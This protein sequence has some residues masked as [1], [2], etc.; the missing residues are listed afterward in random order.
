MFYCDLKSKRNLVVLLV[1]S[2][3]V[4]IIVNVAIKSNIQYTKRKATTRGLSR[5]IG[6]LEESSGYVLVKDYPN[7]V[8]SA[9][10]GLL[11]LQCW[12]GAVSKNVRIVEPF[13]VEESRLGFSLEWDDSVLLKTEVVTLS[14]FFDLDKWQRQLHSMGQKYTHAVMEDWRKFLKSAP[15][16]LIV[17]ARESNKARRNSSSQ[18]FYKAV[19]SW[20]SKHDFKIV[21]EVL[22]KEKKY[23]F[24]K[25][26]KLIYGR[27]PPNKVV[28][29]FEQWG[30]IAGKIYP[31]SYTITGINQCLK[32]KYTKF[33]FEISKGLIK[34]SKK[35]AHKYLPGQ[36]KRYVSVMLR[37]ERIGLHSLRWNSTI[38][39]G[40][41]EKCLMAINQKVQ[42]MTN[43]YNLTGVFIAIDYTKY[44]S[45]RLRS[46]NS[47]NFMNNTFLDSIR[48]QLFRMME[49]YGNRLTVT[50][51]EESFEN[52]SSI[53]ASGYVAQMQKYLASSARCLVLAGG[54]TF[55]SSAYQLYQSLHPGSDNCVV[56]IKECSR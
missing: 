39:R 42:S 41:F 30:G 23:S 18:T 36:S 49:P 6:S 54:G 26:K 35:Y 3:F 44:G 12:A 46:N 22:I 5:L 48:N 15:R 21:R 14:D 34:D 53:K 50:E 51:W 9:S 32:G 56:D 11:S 10:F 29:F 38:G 43:S 33:L 20:V 25:F 16:D 4:L 40:V 27:F 8:T 1:V 31:L 28:V 13:I 19:S 7:Q 52:T 17:V 45:L 24:R 37:T 55:H 47:Y 2:V